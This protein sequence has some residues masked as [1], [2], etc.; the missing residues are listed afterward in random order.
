MNQIL[1]RPTEA[2]EALGIS[3]SRVYELLASGELESITIGRSRRVPV[4]A[5]DR[6]VESRL[7]SDEPKE[8]S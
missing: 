1:I 5:I 4:V 8:L 2:A 3:R 6:F 7:Q